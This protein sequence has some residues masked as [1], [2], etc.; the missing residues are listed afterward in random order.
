MSRPQT[1]PTVLDKVLTLDAGLREN[2]SE[3][4]FFIKE[5]EK[6]LLYV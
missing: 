5:N 3:T 4:Q 2:Q 6:W 1:T